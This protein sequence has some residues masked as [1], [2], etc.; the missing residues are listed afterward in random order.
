MPKSDSFTNPAEVSRR[1]AGFKSRWTERFSLCKYVNPC[2]IWK[3]SEARTCSLMA[4][5]PRRSASYSPSSE[6]V[7]QYSSTR[8][9]EPS[10]WK[11]S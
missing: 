6:P 4:C 10:W 3:R 2:T 8:C 11:A 1:F 5:P 7:S 9:S